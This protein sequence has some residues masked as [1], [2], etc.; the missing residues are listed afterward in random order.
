MAT[1]TRLILLVITVSL[2]VLQ[3]A[4]VPAAAA[5]GGGV[6]LHVD[7]KQVMVDNGV[8]QLTLSR[9]AGRITGVRYGGEGNLLHY[10]KGKGGKNTGGYWDMVWNIPGAQQGL[11]T[12][13]DGSE[14][15]V[16]TQTEEQVELSFRSTYDPARGNG[17]RLNID[18]RF[19]VLKGSSGFYTYAILEHA[20]DTPAID[21]SLARIAFKLNTERFNYMAVS[22][23]IQRYMPR[24]SDREAPRSSPLAY[25]EAVLL[26]DPSDPQFKG[27][28]D[29]KYQY[30]L[31]S[32]D[33][34]V[35]GWVSS[36]HPNPIGFWLVTPSNEFKSGGPLKRD[37]T[38]HVGPTCLSVFH[39]SHYV[40]DDIAARIKDGEYWKKVM[41]PVFVYLNSNPPKGDPRAL[42]EDAK[43]AA[44]AEAAKWPYSFP[45]SPDFHKAGERASVTGRL[46]VT[47]SHVNMP[48][49]AAYVGLAAPGQ[50]GSWATESKGYQFWTRASNTSGE[51]SIDNVRAGD[52]NLYAWVP[53]VL[54]DY[55]H[56]TRVT[57]TP[58]KKINLGDLVFEPPRSGPTLWEIGVPDRSAAEMFIPDTDPKYPTNK[59]F[60][61]NDKYR[62]YG[63]WE[64]YAELYPTDDPV[65]TVG[66][67][68]HSKDWFFAHVTRK[69]GDSIVPTTRQIQFHLDHVVPDG[70]YTLRVALAAAHMSRLQVQVNGAARR[71]AGTFG[72][73]AFG[74]GNAIARHG[75]HGTQWS[76]EFPIRGSL[77]RQGDNA[78]QITETRALSIFFGVMY[79]YIRL[80]G[81]AGSR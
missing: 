10:S 29:D 24:D 54:G 53:G 63:L 38:S 45:E 51:F 55:M 5:L 74:E 61:N 40:G 76:F 20:A 42:W 72:T 12:T 73:L 31:D 17:V 13:L 14:F 79:D 41:G 25:R 32:K 8:V 30:T 35:H 23:G 16:V 19:V 3:V 48:A 47:D 34:R 22:D 46:L 65:Y 15:R 33:N 36:G 21:I 43:A 44:E 64:R 70:T 75:D 2:L 11:S 39:G 18:K 71:G 68:H 77:L 58:G 60:L 80:E 62:Q 9:P 4:A 37:L 1:T 6:T 59:L 78:I 81:P 57:V 67:S 66:E 26:V 50:P 7:R 52:Y 69:V 27:E 56:T 28:V 49:R